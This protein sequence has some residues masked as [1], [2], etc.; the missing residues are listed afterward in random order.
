M[1]ANPEKPSEILY[2]E[3]LP[4]PEELAA[5]ALLIHDEFLLTLGDGEL[6][7]WLRR[8]PVRY[9]VTAGEGL[10]EL[11]AFPE[12]VEALLHRAAP[13]TASSLSVVAVG[14]GSVGDFAGF[15]ASVFK[16]GVG[17]VQIPSTW[18]AALDS[19]HG[20]KTALNVGR[21]KNQ[22]GSYAF[23]QRIYLCRPLLELQPPPRAQEA[24]GE[25]AK[26]ALIDGGPWVEALTAEVTPA[27]AD[28]VLWRFLPEAVAAK[29]R[30]VTRD[31]FERLGLRQHLNLGHTVGHVLET[32]YGLPHGVAVAQGLHFALHFSTQ[33]GLLPAAELTRILSWLE[34]RF[35]LFDRRPSLHR[36]R[37]GR[38]L[39][40]LGQDKK[41]SA[42]TALRFVF[43]RG[44]GR[45]EVAEVSLFELVAEAVRQG[46][47]L[48]DSES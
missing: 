41:R 9:A 14:G 26:I 42:A 7:G 13:L 20:G 29:W 25:L 27:A 35:G 2:T 15:F 28:A 34:G 1:T 30:I 39:E 46:Y 11:A 6:N 22:I 5:E 12:H 10:K 38:F 19:A 43:L 33:R 17:L 3:R 16:R 21:M 32:L 18:L 8:F 48:P 44:F 45:P 36:L 47:V 24:F 31:P 23:A 4:A 37:Q 40:V